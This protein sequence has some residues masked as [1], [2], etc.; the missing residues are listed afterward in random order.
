M[1]NLCDTGNPVGL[2]KDCLAFPS[3]VKNIAIVDTAAKFDSLEEALSLSEWQ[4]K[5]QVA[6]G[7]YIPLGLANSEDTTDDPEIKS[8][9]LGYK[10][11]ASEPNPSAIVY[12]L[13]NPCDFKDV[14]KTLR[15][16]T[17]GI[18][19]LFENGQI[20]G[21]FNEVGEFKPFK[22]SLFATP[23]KIHDNANTENA[24]K[25][26]IN[27]QSNDE[28]KERAFLTPSWGLSL[29]PEAMPNG[30]NLRQTSVVTSGEFTV[31]VSDR[32]G[33]GVTGLDLADFEMI[34]SNNADLEFASVTD[35]G[36]GN[37]TVTVD[38][39]ATPTPAVFGAGE[40]ISFRVNVIATLLTTD[41]SGT[42]TVNA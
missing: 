10:F 26:W 34:D 14:V 22:A 6:D 33:S 39:G 24:Y 36:N 32:C 35:D 28:H 31:N 23:F 37:Y 30:L 1:K 18:Y 21:W 7:F 20:G 25:V 2:N 27:Y 41:I 12:L 42:I 15:G 3:R 11:V 9:A 5:I 4:G 38:D 16:G 17:Y 40:Y 8:T 29:L 19:L 13:S